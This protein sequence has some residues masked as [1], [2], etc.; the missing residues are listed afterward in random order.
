MT[1]P[2]AVVLL[3]L[4]AASAS[5][6]QCPVPLY[7]AEW[8]T[9]LP[10]P[11]SDPDCA[12]VKVLLP[13]YARLRDRAGF[14]AKTLPLVTLKYEQFN[15]FHSGE[16]KSVAVTTGFLHGKRDV[17]VALNIL[18]HE[19]GHAVQDRGPEGVEKKKVWAEV[20]EM[21]KDSDYQARNVWAE[22]Q[23]RYEGQADGIAQQL[24]AEAGY[25]AGTAR[26]GTQRVFQCDLETVSWNTHP[27]GGRR[28]VDATLSE[29]YIGRLAKA[30][31][32]VTGVQFEG[33]ERGDASGTTTFTPLVKLDDYGS[34]GELMPGRFV[35]SD[36]KLPPPPPGAS[37][38]ARKR[39]A[40]ARAAWE[41]LVV[42]PFAAAV[43]EVALESSTTDRILE[44]CGT[45]GARDQ[46]E[47]EGLTT[48]LVRVVRA[49]FQD[50]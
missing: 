6:A 10:F 33:G 11:D 12:L 48:W 14:T 27:A 23:R 34:H 21:Q 32:A 5:A 4:L 35:A 22:F 30:R 9:S 29:R 46:A 42:K 47:D 31:A 18:A 28:I 36:L 26:M 38:R 37:P 16:K 2:L 7:D 20:L 25:P 15:A 17:Y 49:E 3:S 24:L 13:D 40:E 8:K 50:D 45:K 44:S 19:I 41:R 39:D 1:A 43:D